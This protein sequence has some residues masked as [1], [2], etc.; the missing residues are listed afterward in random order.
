MTVLKAAVELLDVLLT[1]PPRYTGGFPST[2]LTSVGAPSSTCSWARVPFG[3]AFF[4]LFT[5]SRWLAH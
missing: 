1:N 5:R 4:F 2:A 3:A